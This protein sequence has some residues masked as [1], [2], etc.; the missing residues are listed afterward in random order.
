MKLT[1]LITSI[2][3][4][5][6]SSAMAS[7][8][9]KVEPIQVMVLGSYHFANPGQ[10][11]VNAKVDDVTTAERQ[12]ELQALI[13]SLAEF[14]P[15]R[16]LIERQ[17]HDDSFI[18]DEFKA[19]K[20][21]DLNKNR[22]ENVQ[23]GYRLAHRLGHD[24]VYGFDEQ[25]AHGEPDYFPM[26]QVQTFAKEND[27]L[28]QLGILIGGVQKKAKAFEEMQKCKSI[29]SLL[30]LENEPAEIR[31]WH[32][33]LYYSLLGYGDRDNQAGAELNAYWYMRNAKMFAKIDL[34]AEPGEKIFVLVGAG[35]KYWL[36]HFLDSAPGFQSADPRPYLEKAAAQVTP[37]SA[38]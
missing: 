2:S 23:I 17:V 16:V 35:H 29:P 13:K 34:I 22:N 8:K 3:L 1:A 24:A 6:T 26:G 7:E 10:D 15:D 25:P 9:Q 18:V 30:L 37:K 33:K 27:R 5:I 38:C 28:G 19:Y 31:Y 4:A 21:F 32:N 14:D 20:P 12:R 36:E 11:V